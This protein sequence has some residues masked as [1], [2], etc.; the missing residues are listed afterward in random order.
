MSYL[1]G[2]SQL[3]R[4]DDSTFVAFA[5]DLCISTST[6][7]RHTVEINVGGLVMGATVAQLA[8]TWS[9]KLTSTSV[10][11]CLFQLLLLWTRTP[12]TGH[13]LM[14]EHGQSPTAPTVRCS[15]DSLWCLIEDTSS[16]SPPIDNGDHISIAITIIRAGRIAHG[17]FHNPVAV[18]EETT[19]TDS[20]F[21]FVRLLISSPGAAPINPHTHP[22][23]PSTPRVLLRNY[24]AMDVVFISAA[25]AMVSQTNDTTNYEL[26]TA[27]G[28]EL[29]L[30]ITTYLTHIWWAQDVYKDVSV[31]FQPLFYTIES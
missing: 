21:D 20:N 12:V 19:T 25:T 7:Q 1:I 29:E 9:L 23:Q 22:K 13:S 10:D 2:N 5:T 3:S 4:S 11:T 6:S 8:L 24:W 16:L 17:W 31:V 18:N 30:L 14:D 15:F 28:R 26:L 27:S